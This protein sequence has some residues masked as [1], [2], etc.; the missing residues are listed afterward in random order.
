MPEILTQI[1]GQ[2]QQQ[3]I[4]TV[5]DARGDIDLLTNKL[6]A[7]SVL[8]VEPGGSGP[9]Q[10]DSLGN[11]RG[12]N[13][14]DLQRVRSADT[15]V[16]SGIQSSILG[17]L[18]NTASGSSTV[19]C[20]GETNVSGANRSGIVAGRINTTTLGASDCAILAGREGNITSAGGRCAIVA[21]LENTASGIDCAIVSGR[22]NVA[23]GVRSAVV[24]GLQNTSSGQYSAI[25]S[26]LLCT[27]SG[28]NSSAQGDRAVAPN[29][30]EAAQGAGQHDT[31]PGSA[32]ASNFVV[33]NT[34]TNAT[35]TDLFLDGT[36]AVMLMP[37]NSCW[38]FSA[39]VTGLQTN[40]TNGAGYRIE[41][42]LRR[43][44]ATVPVLVGTVAVTTI[45]EDVAAWTAN[46]AVS[47][48]GLAINVTGAAATTINWTARVS[49]AQTIVEG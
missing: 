41:G 49:V 48:N 9:L 35:A 30:G 40:G 39:L 8:I 45:G 16:A 43:D 28:A 34:T 46:A 17:G 11:T 22:L 3:P 20:G 15:Q 29:L 38:A 14:T 4:G 5:L 6:T 32:Q 19:V 42:V 25:V 18:D 31:T 26:G 13:S 37:N 23:S 33:F 12:N 44:G 36:S 47:G 24:T 21:G 1:G 2:I 27:A 10:A 7:T